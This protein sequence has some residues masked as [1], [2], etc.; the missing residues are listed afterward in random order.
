MV[1]SFMDN[2][3]TEPEKRFMDGHLAGCADCRTEQAELT[4]LSGILNELDDIDL[5]PGFDRTFWQKIDAL[6]GKKR[7][8]FFGEWMAARWRLA[9]API[10][11]VLILIGGVMMRHK[12]VTLTS[13]DIF[14]VDHMDL[15]DDYDV[16]NNLDVV[17]D[18]DIL[19]HMKE[20]S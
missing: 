20:S 18:M 4:R 19:M 15:M 3:L 7:R 11:I 17:E 6:D 8:T 13:E 2:E 14:M 10:F 16:V 5:S 9:F 1:Q 12:P